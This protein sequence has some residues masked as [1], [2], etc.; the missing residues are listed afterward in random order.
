MDSLYNKL[1]NKKLFYNCPY[2]NGEWIK[3]SQKVNVYN[4]ANGEIIDFIYCCSDEEVKES[5]SAA[6]KSF[7]AWSKST[8]KYRS[9]LLR[10]WYEAIIDNKEDLAILMTLEQGKPKHESLQEI[11]YAASF[12]EWF[13]EEAKRIDQR[14]ISIN[15]NSHGLIT[16]EAVGVC[17]IITPWN[18]PTAMI[19]R[20]VGAAFAAG[21]CVVL[22][23]ALETPFSAL[24]LVRLAETVGIPPGVLNVVIGDAKIIGKEITSN[25]DIRK[26]SFTGSTAVGKLLM[27]QSSKTLKRLSLELG[28]NAPFII[29]EDADIDLSI[30]KLVSCKFRN[31]GQTCISVN[32]VFIHK[33]IYNDFIE[34]L[35]ISVKKLK[36]GNGL[37][38]GVSQGPLISINAIKKIEYFIEK[39]VDNGAQ[40]LLGGKR[41]KQGELFFEPTVIT[42]VKDHMEIS[43]EE[44]FGPVISL[45]TFESEEEVIKRSNATPYGL[46]AYIMSN[47]KQKAWD[48]AKELEYGMIGINETNISSETTPFGGI[49]DSGFGRE[50][51]FMGI[52]EYLATK[53]IVI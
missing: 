25:K 32:R 30:Q 29:C 2:I 35:I 52:E 34:K 3:T 27:E 37:E 26:I 9:M 53:Y 16:K 41:D 43:C 4:P 10:K 13:A 51:S 39:A 7:K 22:K 14:L 44:I 45:T 15:S 19:T 6:K 23:P 20:K 40:I 21:C 36:L 49:K 38:E 47:N 33:N 31:N 18:F 17:G 5:I 1:K 11:N 46:A 12:V 24:A 50:G 28:G 8:P 42:N 48:I